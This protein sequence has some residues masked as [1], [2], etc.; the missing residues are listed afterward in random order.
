MFVG[1]G[2]DVGK[3]VVSAGICRVL[4]QDGFA[5]APFKAQNM[6]LNSYV[7]PTGGE[8]GR[9]Q[10]VQAEACCLCPHTDMNPI[11]LK[12]TSNSTSQIILHGKAIGSQSAS[13]YFL[14]NNKEPLFLEALK[15]Y[16]RLNSEYNPIV[17]EGAGSISELNLKHRD[18]TNMRMALATGAAVYLVADIDKGGIFASV[19]GTIALLNA[20]ERK[21]VKGILINK[22][23]G[24]IR[25]FQDGTAQIEELTG[26][27]V[28][29]ILPYF[30]GIY[31]DDEDSVVLKGKQSCA[32]AERVN[33]CVI[34]CGKMSNFT[35]FS[36]LEHIDGVQ[37][38]YSNQISQIERADV[39]ILPGSKNT[40]ADLE[41]LHNNGVAMA[42]KK[43]FEKGKSILGICGGY[44]MLGH[45]VCDPD[46]VD[47]GLKRIG[48]I[49]ILPVSTVNATEKITKQEQFFYKNGSK[50]CRGY[51]IHMGRTTL[52]ESEPKPLVVTDS[53]KG[54]GY[55]LRDNVWGTY[56][57]GI[58]D[59]AEVVRDVL[60]PFKDRVAEPRDFNKFKDEQYDKLADVIRENVDME[61]LYSHLKE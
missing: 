48:G 36:A 55:L 9:A 19:Y 38:Y 49:G 53:G 18:I 23:R 17:L 41:E 1:T 29:G 54:D 32:D 25:L 21:A 44:Q 47:G 4:K 6:S 22:F 24:D 11:L 45:E 57:H 60:S 43:E 52:V 14:G 37:L 56:M 2:S 16:Q 28:V 58:F 26:I 13:E 8:L 61:L 12:P 39:I 50:L 10:A 42:I 5:P 27:P 31:I 35:D 34:Q 33:I 20:E 59:N 3:S 40:I 15:S 7:T 51:E 30:E 46:N